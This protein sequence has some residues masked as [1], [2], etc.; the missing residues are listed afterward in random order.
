[1]E[2]FLSSKCGM[3]NIAGKHA[4]AAGGGQLLKNAVELRAVAGPWILGQRFH[5][6]GIKA[7][8]LPGKTVVEVTCQQTGQHRK[9]ILPLSQRGNPER[10]AAAFQ[11]RAPDQRFLRCG[12]KRIDQLTAGG[13]PGNV[14][15]FQPLPLLSVGKLFR[16]F[17]PEH[18]A[19]FI[20]RRIFL[21][22]Q[23]MPG[24]I[25]H[26][27]AVDHKLRPVAEGIEIG[28]RRQQC[29]QVAAFFGQNERRSQAGDRLD[30]LLDNLLHGSDIIVEIGGF[31]CF[32]ISYRV[33]RGG[34][35]HTQMEYL[36]SANRMAA[37]EETRNEITGFRLVCTE[38][39]PH[40]VRAVQ[41]LH[42]W[43]RNVSQS[44]PQWKKKEEPIFQK[45]LIY[46][47][48]PETAS[49]G[50]F[51]PHNHV[52]SIALLKNGDL[53]ATWFSAKKECGRELTVLASRL[54]YGHEQWDPADEFY[55]IADRNMSSTAIVQ[56][57]DGRLYHFNG[58]AM[59]GTEFHLVSI[60]RYSEDNGV[61][62]S[63]EQYLNSEYST[64][65]PICAPVIDLEGR[66]LVPADQYDMETMQQGTV[67]FR[68]N[69]A[70]DR[71]EQQTCYGKDR[72]NFL[73]THGTAGWIAGVH[74]AVL[75][76]KDGRLLA[77]GRSESRCGRQLMEGKMPMSLSENMGRSWSYRAAPF[78][79]IG[80][81]QRCCLLRL[82]E[83]AIVFFSFTDPQ[84]D[85]QSGN[86]RGMDLTD[87][88]GKV[89]HGYGLYAAVS[90]DEGATWPVQRLITTAKPPQ[91]YD[92]GASCPTFIMDETH[93][94]P[95]GYM[96]AVQAPDGMIHLISSRLHYRFNLLWLMADHSLG[97]TE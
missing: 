13:K 1:M 40:F 49:E 17:D 58:I 24:R 22:Q 45:L 18:P 26:L 85:L 82:S 53:F 54:R 68:S 90:F 67:L 65:K 56:H 20:K 77:F 37:L 88:H 2:L 89:L 38:V 29:G 72:E 80:Y 73:T 50:P 33:T 3:N 43:Q 78:P 91:E 21:L 12:R 39:Q 6:V 5:A 75:P 16:V 81:A 87:A 74:G 93:A 7:D 79:P 34:S 96:Q 94:Q 19:I 41:R 44:E 70:L 69:A 28:E 4:A 59:S 61:T 95:Q 97:Q 47:R 35:V 86:I 10:E 51:Y 42:Y 23:H 31:V 32:F 8:D 71:F 15:V 92:P 62:W 52:P 46:V 57:P 30:G 84:Y 63:R 9:I 55:K 66:I 76:L 83:G 25:R 27:G 48:P 60:F 64:N 11:Q 14:S 36:R